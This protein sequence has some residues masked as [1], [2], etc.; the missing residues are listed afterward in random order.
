[1]A[2]RMHFFLRCL[3]GIIV[4]VAF[5]PAFLNAAEPS[6]P[7]LVYHRFG[8]VR[9]DSMTVTTEH[10]KQQLALLCK[11]RF[12][13][14][15]LADFV[16]WRLGRGPAPPP[17]S[18]VL[19][20]DDGHVSVYREARSIITGNCLPVTLFIY[21]S[22]ISHA[23]YAMTWEQLSKLAATQY[24]TVQSHTFWHPN[25]KQESKRLDRSAYAA[26]VDRQFRRSQAI[27]EERFQRRV[28]FLAWPFGIY[29]PYLM[30]RAGAAGYEAAFTIEC[31]AATLADPVLALPRCPVSDSE[32]GP[33]F[34]EFLDSAIRRA[35]N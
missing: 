16:A 9:A 23:S 20:F 1:M 19:T 26:L 31:R 17:R 5:S 2:N 32:V 34:L 33:R 6:V 11:N 7:I 30:N 10:F 24:F 18:V 35:R 28:P 14:I 22:C 29:D 27:L 4:S 15:P 12:S 13:I 25:F 3:V 8:A 21:P